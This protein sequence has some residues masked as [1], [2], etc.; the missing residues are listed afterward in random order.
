MWLWEQTSTP[1]GG[2]CTDLQTEDISFQEQW[3]FVFFSIFSMSSSNFKISI[4]ERGQV[5][6]KRTHENKLWMI[7]EGKLDR[8]Q[9][10]FYFVP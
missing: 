8:S 1:L 2:V 4:A 9:P 3:G 6:Q 10:L 7:F 5:R